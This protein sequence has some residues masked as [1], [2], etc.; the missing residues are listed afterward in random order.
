[1]YNSMMSKLNE[2]LKP[3]TMT[4]FSTSQGI[5]AGTLLVPG[6]SQAGI[7]I[8]PTVTAQKITS[9]AS[10]MQSDRNVALP[11]PAAA[12]LGKARSFS[13]SFVGTHSSRSSGST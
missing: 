1:M 2:L 6:C 12:G 10:F 13:L 11:H 7:A 9:Y 3:R 4:Q 8:R 5:Q